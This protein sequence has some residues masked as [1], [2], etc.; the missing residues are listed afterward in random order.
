MPW[1]KAETQE[2]QQRYYHVFE[3]GELKLLVSDM[4]GI[5]VLDEYYDE[6]NWCLILEKTHETI[7]KM[8]T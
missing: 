4:E 6:G 5:Q 3:K 2:T 8:E 1:K 7:N